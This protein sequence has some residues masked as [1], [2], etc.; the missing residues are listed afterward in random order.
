MG[1]VGGRA[2]CLRPHFLGKVGRLA[3]PSSLG[4]IGGRCAR[5][6]RDPVF[7]SYLTIVAL[8]ISVFRQALLK[9]RRVPGEALGC[10]GH[11]KPVYSRGSI[12]NL[13]S[14]TVRGAAID[15]PNKYYLNP[16]KI[17][18]SATGHDKRFL[19][20]LCF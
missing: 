3:S 4:I 17:V 13:V 15:V 10:A 11:G 20:L 16:P 19:D 8:A 2:S 5:A 12:G 1:I 9:R 6:P 14:P 7:A 18:N